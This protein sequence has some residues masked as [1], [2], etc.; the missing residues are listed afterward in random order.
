[1]KML[2]AFNPQDMKNNMYA[3]RGRWWTAAVM[4]APD[5]DVAA[6]MS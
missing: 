6:E 4:A 2:V 1:M 5:A 3:S